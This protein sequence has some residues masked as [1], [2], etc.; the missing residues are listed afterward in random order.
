MTELIIIF[1]AVMILVAFWI[2]RRYERNK[3]KGE[4]IDD[5]DRIDRIKA[6]ANALSDDDIKQLCEY[7][8]KGIL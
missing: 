6:D 4:H 3:I 5:R 7:F 8:K 1:E 2:G